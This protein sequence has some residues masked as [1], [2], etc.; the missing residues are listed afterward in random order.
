MNTPKPAD[1]PPGPP[2]SHETAQAA[3]AA[4]AGTARPVAFAAPDD[5]DELARAD[6]YGLLAELW[7]APP[8][9]A[10]LKQFNTVVTQ[11]PQ[12]GTFL[13]PPWEHLVAAMRAITVA[14]AKEEYDTLFGG[15]GKP[16]VFLYASYHLTGHLNERPLVHLRTDLATLG[17]ARDDNRAETEDHVAYLFELMRYLIAGDD[18]A[19]CNLEQQRRVFRAH[20]QPWLDLMCAA[21]QAHPRARTYAALAAF[22]QAWVQVETQAFDMLEA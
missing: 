8:G 7:M 16:E 20:I 3:R 22:T 14:S 2:Q 6:L 13:E 10:L 9:D 11:A 1:V 18:V 5:S 19:V 15:I 17:L 4:S 12:P 21:V